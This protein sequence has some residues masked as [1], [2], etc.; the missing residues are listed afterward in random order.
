MKKVRS[1]NVSLGGESGEQGMMKMV[2][3]SVLSVFWDTGRTLAMVSAR[4]LCGIKGEKED[5]RGFSAPEAGE[6]GRK[7]E[8]LLVI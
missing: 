4:V 5:S 6:G 2:L 3:W 8:D 1:D 7:E